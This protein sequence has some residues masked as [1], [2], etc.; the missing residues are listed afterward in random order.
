MNL[1]DRGRVLYPELPGIGENI[2]LVIESRDD[3]LVTGSEI[4]A[5]WAGEADNYTFNDPRW[6]ISESFK[7]TYCV[8]SNY[9]GCV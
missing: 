2:H 5:L 1:A 7:H 6:N 9:N 4:V 8:G 3:H